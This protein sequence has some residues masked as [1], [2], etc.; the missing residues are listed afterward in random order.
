M[1]QFKL[2]FSLEELIILSKYIVPRRF[3]RRHSQKTI[4]L[5]GTLSSIYVIC[6]LDTLLRPRG[7]FENCEFVVWPD[8]V[9]VFC[10][11]N[12]QLCL[13]VITITHRGKWFLILRKLRR[14][15]RD[16]WK[17]A[18]A[19]FFIIK[20]KFQWI[21]ISCRFSSLDIYLTTRFMSYRNW[22]FS[23]ILSDCAT[24]NLS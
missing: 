23:T 24:Q 22:D 7:N 1:H 6:T 10:L 14:F 16:I 9:S 4:L 15:L 12:G 11:F 21:P 8:V 17:Q 20:V 13:H 19:I 5:L 18:D 2:L 3:R